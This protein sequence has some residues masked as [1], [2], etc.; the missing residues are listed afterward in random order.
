MV[1]S[2]TTDIQPLTEEEQLLK[3]LAAGEYQAFWSLFQQH[4]DHL[5]RCCLKWMDGNSTEAED[6]LSQAMLKAF[7]KAHKYAEKIQNFKFWITK[8]IRNYWL[9]LKRHQGLKTLEYIEWYGEQEEREWISLQD[10]PASALENDEQKRVI[11][12]AINQLPIRLHETFVLHFYQEFS[13]QEI[14]KQQQ[15]SYP[16]VCKRISQARAILR[17][18]LRGYFIGEENLLIKSL[19]TPAVTELATEELSQQNREEVDT[20]VDEPVTSSVGGA[21]AATVVGE[22][23]IEVVRFQPPSE[24]E[25]IAPTS[26]ATLSI[27]KTADSCIPATGSEWPLAAI[28]AWI[29][30]EEK[31][32]I[33]DC[34]WRLMQWMQK[35]HQV[36]QWAEKYRRKIGSP[37]GSGFPANQSLIKSLSPMKIGENFPV[38][39]TCSKGADF[40]DNVKPGPRIYAIGIGL[41]RGQI[42]GF[43][44]PFVIG[45]KMLPR[46]KEL[47]N[48]S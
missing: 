46:L 45:S 40:P 1:Q 29:H 22:E 37:P 8:L 42:P 17:E 28:W 11:R 6:L 16:N 31:T 38:N 4:Q 48:L 14:A 26:H 10:S 30:V 19:V 33:W 41:G 23:P 9:D 5:F 47:S 36:R 21:I 39:L 25:A 18:E 20:P 32:R 24:L 13:H 35:L 3:P 43:L 12:R 44:A 27:K 34:L 7:K 15:I 2:T